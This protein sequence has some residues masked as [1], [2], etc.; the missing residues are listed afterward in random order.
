[1][2]HSAMSVEVIVPH[3]KRGGNTGYTPAMAKVMVSL[4]DELLRDLDTAAHRDGDTRSGYLRK[5]AEAELSRRSRDRAERI[6]AI[7]AGATPQRRGGDVAARV[8]AH[9]PDR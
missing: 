4:P 2:T 3:L 5:L 8:K 6:A 9:R 1:M 7:T